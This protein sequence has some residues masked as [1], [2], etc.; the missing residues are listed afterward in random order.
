M[1]INLQPSKICSSRAIAL[2]AVLTPALFA[3]ACVGPPANELAEKWGMIESNASECPVAVD[4]TITDT[5]NIGYQPLPVGDMLVYERGLLEACMPNATINWQR[6][7]SSAEIVQTFGTG[8]L[9]IVTLG[10][11]GTSRSLSKPL[12]YDAK[13]IWV[14]DKIGTAEALVARDPNITSITDLKGK[15]VAV[16]SASTVHY[17][18]LRSMENAGM[19]ANDVKLVFMGPD[20]ILAGWHTGSLD[21]TWIWEPTLSEIKKDAHVV[22]TSEDAANIGA[23]TYDLSMARREFTEQSPE[24]LK[25]WW[26]L[27]DYAAREINRDPEGAAASVA[28]PLGA[29]AAT[30]RE[31]FKG[32][33]YPT[34]EEIQGEDLLG[35][36]IGDHLHS[37]AQ[38][39]NSVGEIDKE[40]DL[41]YYREALLVPKI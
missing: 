28:I 5:V 37:A 39:L 12:A 29:E 13:V 3:T 19:T 25:K 16:A 31:Q 23:P 38:F 8:D 27:E 15:S 22:M 32:Y 7:E 35:G 30:V 33:T 34:I 18:L 41:S 24:F 26:E 1:A 14:H 21:A 9:D 6:F 36:G 11:P 10:S 4:E 40:S 17:A 20:K 2:A